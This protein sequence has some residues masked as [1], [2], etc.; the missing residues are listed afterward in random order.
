MTKA[1]AL[2]DLL[3][4]LERLLDSAF[5]EEEAFNPT[6]YYVDGDDLRSAYDAYHVYETLEHEPNGRP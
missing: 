4:K 2:E 3:V 1:E 5:S 6:R